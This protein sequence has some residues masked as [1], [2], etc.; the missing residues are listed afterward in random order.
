MTRQAVYKAY[1]GEVTPSEFAYYYIPT[2]REGLE[3]ISGGYRRSRVLTEQGEEDVGGMGG[4][5]GAGR[6]LRGANKQ[7]ASE[8]M[9][10]RRPLAAGREVYV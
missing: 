3:D 7:S 5:G 2:V 8:R 6:V 1:S 10:G 4:G 9:V